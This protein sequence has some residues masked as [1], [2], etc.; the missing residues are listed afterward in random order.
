M[1]I[2]ITYFKHKQIHQKTWKI[3]GN[4]GTN[5][6][7]HVLVNNRRKSAIQDVRVFRGANCDSD[8][9]LVV[10][11]V[12]QKL[13]KEYGNK[14]V[15][16][17]KWNVEALEDQRTKRIY[18]KQ[19]SHYNNEIEVEEDINLEWINF[20]LVANSAA[21]STVGKKERKQKQEWFDE[22]CQLK[23]KEKLNT[24]EICAEKY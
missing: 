1:V 2:A 3:P 13:A 8:H 20:K 23:I 9:Y 4:Y 24:S 16:V 7:D 15:R 22:E 17:N 10:V 5:Q 19:I 14:D 18:M 12:R 6:I 11:K 21:M